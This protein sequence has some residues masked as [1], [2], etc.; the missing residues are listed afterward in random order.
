[1]KWNVNS[2]FSR[3]LV[4]FRERG[5][6][7]TKFF[8]GIYRGP[9]HFISTDQPSGPASLALLI[10]VQRMPCLAELRDGH[11]FVRTLGRLGESGR[12]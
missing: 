11:A 5:R 6:V 8:T 7:E 1:M 3:T 12:G 2:D 4:Y 9:K 10:E